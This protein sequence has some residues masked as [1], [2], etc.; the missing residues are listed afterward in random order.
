MS[1]TLT[2]IKVAVI[3]IEISRIEIYAAAWRGT[4]TYS[5]VQ[6]EIYPTK[7]L[8]RKTYPA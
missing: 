4:E 6:A 8:G 3:V 7:S 1:V 2:E 5:T